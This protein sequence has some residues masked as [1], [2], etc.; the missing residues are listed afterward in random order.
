MASTEQYSSTGDFRKP[1]AGKL[2][3]VQVPGT[4]DKTIPGDDNL[5]NQRSENSYSCCGMKPLKKDNNP[6]ETVK[7]D[8]D[9]QE[10]HPTYLKYGDKKTEV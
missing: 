3:E 1:V 10:Y 7:K 2:V 4:K 8:Y 6:V 5:Y 9:Y